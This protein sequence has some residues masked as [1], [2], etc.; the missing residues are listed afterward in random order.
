[1]CQPYIESATALSDLLKNAKMK[2]DVSLLMALKKEQKQGGMLSFVT[3]NKQQSENSQIYDCN[4]YIV[5][6]GSEQ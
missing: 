5:C 4:P 1:M 3:K 6:S 2:K